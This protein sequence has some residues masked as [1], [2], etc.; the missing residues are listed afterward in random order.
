MERQSPITRPDQQQ[1]R[2][3]PEL[4][5]P[6]APDS[7]SSATGTQLLDARSSRFP[8]EADLGWDG[9]CLLKTVCKERNNE[10]LSPI[11]DNHSVWPKGP[12]AFLQ[13]CNTLPLDTSY[14]FWE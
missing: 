6:G 12:Q 2:M 13:T 5:L 10:T 8:A 7:S 14:S 4:R 1:T 9:H 3:P 11:L